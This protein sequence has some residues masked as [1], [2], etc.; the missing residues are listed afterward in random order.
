MARNKNIRFMNNQFATSANLTVSSEQATFPGSNVLNER[1]SKVWSPNGAFIIDDTNNKVY[2]STGT[3]EITITNGTY[4]GTTLAAQIQTDMNLVSAN[5][6]CT[7]STSTNRFTLDN[8]NTAA[9]AMQFTTNAIW[10]TIGFLTT[11]EIVV[12]AAF[13]PAI[14]DEPRIHSEEFIKVDLG[15]Q[16]DPT[17]VGLVN[18]IDE[19]FPV[20]E[21]GL[22][23]IQANNVDEFDNPPLSI[24]ATKTKDGILEQIDS[25]TEERAYRYWKIKIVDRT[26][27]AIGP[28]GFKFGYFYIGDHKTFTSTD[29]STLATTRHSH[30][31]MSPEALT[32]T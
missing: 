15:V 12:G 9:L 30:Q 11:T 10:D 25:E 5:W 21:Q 13:D 4:T 24:V 2:L 19:L 18:P 31:P 1:R 3:I 16:I 17:F 29:I 22:V 7:Y 8:P 23:T 14:S 6:T 32:R 26:N 28:Q 27:T 20:S